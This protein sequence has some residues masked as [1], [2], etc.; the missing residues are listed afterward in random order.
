[1]N[2]CKG[3]NAK[4]IVTIYKTVTADRTTTTTS[5]KLEV[6][7]RSQAS[8]SRYYTQYSG[9][10]MISIVAGESAC[11]AC[12]AGT[13]PDA[14]TPSVSIDS[15]QIQL[16]LEQAKAM[17][18]SGKETVTDMSLTKMK[19]VGVFEVDQTLAQSGQFL[20][21]AERWMTF[22]EKRK[23]VPDLKGLK[24]AAAAGVDVEA[25]RKSAI[26]L[27]V[28]AGALEETLEK[29]TSIDKKT[30][31]EK[32]SAI[33]VTAFHA[34][35]E[36]EGQEEKTRVSF[37]QFTGSGAEGMSLC[38]FSSEETYTKTVVWLVD[39]DGRDFSPPSDVKL[40]DIEK[41]SVRVYYTLRK[42][43]RPVVIVEGKDNTTVTYNIRADVKL[44][45][46]PD[47]P[48]GKTISWVPK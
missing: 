48:G 15:T 35:T 34:P 2:L 25:V 29:L 32:A 45:E 40:S 42:V 46:V 7:A 13:R 14:S 31:I 5:Q 43:D 16:F 6:D 23:L 41:S 30:D 1:M 22:E 38:L 10:P 36:V 37:F 26:P 4:A 20:F 19:R 33:L 8:F 24:D 21:H 3:C 17:G 11:K 9:R 39:A 27:D 12:K 18:V 47:G 44:L 28:T